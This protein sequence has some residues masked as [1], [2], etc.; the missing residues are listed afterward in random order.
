VLSSCLITTVRAVAYVSTYLDLCTCRMYKK[1]QRHSRGI[2]TSIALCLTMC[3]WSVHGVTWGSLPT[4]MCLD[5]R[6]GSA[7]CLSSSLMLYASQTCA[8]G[9]SLESKQALAQRRQA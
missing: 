8:R 3:V 7:R 1:R 5:I 9:L 4:Y 6:T 2:A